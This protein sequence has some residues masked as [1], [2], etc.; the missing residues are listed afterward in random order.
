MHKKDVLTAGQ[1]LLNAMG[2]PYYKS[3]DFN[4]YDADERLSGKRNSLVRSQQWASNRVIVL[5]KASA[6]TEA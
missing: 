6:A 3:S 5:N 4:V 1:I 2:K